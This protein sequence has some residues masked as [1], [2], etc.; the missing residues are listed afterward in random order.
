[1]VNDFVHCN[2]SQDYVFPYLDNWTIS[3]MTGKEHDYYLNLAL[4]AG[5]YKSSLIMDQD[6]RKKYQA[7]K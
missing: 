4:T 1:M 7:D 5:R 2:G 6:N 3:A